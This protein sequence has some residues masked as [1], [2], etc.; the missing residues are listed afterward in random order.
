MNPPRTV[1]TIG[2]FDGVHRGHAALVGRARELAEAA[3]HNTRVVT[4]AFDPHPASVLAPERTPARLTTFDQRARFLGAAGADEVVRLEPTGEL[5]S[6]SPNAF[7]ER[8]VAELHPAA[9]VEGPDF[10]F[11]HARAGDVTTLRSLGEELGF[12]VEVVPPVEAVLDDGSLVRASS[13]IARWLLQ[14]GRVRDAAAV[15]GRPYEMVG[16]VERGDRRGRTIGYPTANLVSPNM[17]PAD[18][19]YA[20]RAILDDGREL[21]AAISVGDKPTFG[22]ATRAVEAYILP[23][24]DRPG[25]WST[26]PGLPEYGWGLRLRFEHWIREQIR[27]DGLPALLAQ[28]ERDCDRVRNIMRGAV[29]RPAPQEAACH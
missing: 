13:S 20:G 10:R 21:V 23:D 17:I 5:L 27:F 2:T 19:V 7:V 14:H 29:D 26:L 24:G 11:G 22:G 15:L 3:G 12:T 9:I 28:M 6:L 8:L 16:T 25:Q 18:G 1:V 4:L